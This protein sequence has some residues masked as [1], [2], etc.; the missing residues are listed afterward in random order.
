MGIRHI[1]VLGVALLSGS[2]VWGAEP[3]PL[4]TSPQVPPLTLT[5]APPERGSGVPYVARI[6]V[7]LGERAA[8]ALREQ[9]EAVAYPG[10]GDSPLSL[11]GTRNTSPSGVRSIIPG[12]PLKA[13]LFFHPTTAKALPCFQPQPYVGP[14]SGTFPC[15][16]A[17][18]RGGGDPYFQ[19]CCRPHAALSRSRTDRS[20][21][22]VSEKTLPAIVQEIESPAGYRF[23][24]PEGQKLFEQ[25][26]L[27]AKS[28][29]TLPPRGFWNTPIPRV[30]AVQNPSLP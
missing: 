13:W 23:A 25:L 6:H 8:L 5:V 30:S 4:P 2:A 1:G 10:M 17:A 29:Y 24:R 26:F 3:R 7:P 15:T 28:S 12:S 18:P 27:P 14:I 19:G 9:A 11:H 21:H 20:S 16:S 22:A